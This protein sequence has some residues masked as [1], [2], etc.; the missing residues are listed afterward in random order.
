MVGG[1]SH[2]F[3][4]LEE[5]SNGRNITGGGEGRSSLKVTQGQEEGITIP[6]VSLPA[7]LEL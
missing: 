1:S 6:R 5:K 7:K 3:P 4:K 2:I